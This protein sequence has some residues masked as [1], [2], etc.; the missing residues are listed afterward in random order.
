MT[1]W[2]ST[3]RATSASSQVR[4]IRRTPVR[5]SGVF[6]PRQGAQEWWEPPAQREP[7]ICPLPLHDALPIYRRE[8]LAQR[9][10]REFQV[11]LVLP[12][13]RGRPGQRERRGRKE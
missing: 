11:W 8:R 1:P 2:S 13:R 10:H 3:G 6:W 7:E 12:E 4:A 5:P 9:E